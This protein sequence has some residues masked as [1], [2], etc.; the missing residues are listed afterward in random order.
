M[1]VKIRQMAPAE[2]PAAAE[3]C[4]GGAP[5][6]VSAECR[7]RRR[8]WLQERLGAGLVVLFAVKEGIPKDVTYPDGSRV[9]GEELASIGD[10]LIVGLAEYGPPAVSPHP[11][12]G[13]G[14]IHL[15]CLRVLEP[16]RGRG[17][18]TE[19]ARA[20]VRAARKAGGGS[21][22]AWA[23]D[24]PPYPYGPVGFFKKL[25]FREIVAD[26]P[27][28]LMYLGYGA[29]PPG[30]IKPE[31][32]PYP[33]NRATVFWSGACPGCVWGMKEIAAELERRPDADV[34]LVNTDKRGDVER[35]GAMCGLAVRG[36][37]NEQRAV[38][39]SDV[40]AALERDNR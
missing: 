33:V 14:I 20:F 27:R 8:Y 3:F 25:G 36:K 18:G 37:I 2:V 4:A 17:V 1:R 19:L 16:F 35:Y 21:V 38:T 24:E 39:W 11:V 29:P 5:G 9:P 40:N 28:A 32:L 22:L 34:K 13:A 30:L 31:P 7:R 6:A 15:N 26:G 10:N 12:R 23:G